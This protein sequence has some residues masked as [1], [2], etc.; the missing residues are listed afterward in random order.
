MRFSVKSFVWQAYIRCVRMI[1]ANAIVFSDFFVNSGRHFNHYF[2][3]QHIKVERAPSRKDSAV[4]G[5]PKGIREREKKKKT[6]CNPL[7]SLA[8][9]DDDFSFL[10]LQF[11]R[12]KTSADRRPHLVYINVLLS[13]VLA[14]RFFPFSFDILKKKL[15]RAVRIQ[16]IQEHLF[17]WSVLFY[18]FSFAVPFQV[19]LS[20]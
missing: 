15:R 10:P 19:E 8:D 20:V 7:A 2:K 18:L 1:T 14:L 6:P 4:C 13:L 17:C 3:G 11:Q 9:D 12:L 16:F 5:V